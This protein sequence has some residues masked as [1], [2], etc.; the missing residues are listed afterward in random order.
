M[1]E[2]VDVSTVI[3][4]A[5]S[6]LAP[7]L[8]SR[9]HMVENT[10]VHGLSF[11]G[12]PAKLEQLFYNILLNAVQY[13]AD[14]TLIR[15]R[16]NIT[17]DGFVIAIADAGIGIKRDELGKIFERFYRADRSRSR[18]RGGAGLGL[19]IV[20]AI[21]DAHG[22]GITVESTPDAGTEFLLGF[23]ARKNL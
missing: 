15:I 19:A 8:V 14:G 11:Q 13:S 9:Q 4:R 23:P 2:D 3:A 18:A 21:A 5:Q 12:S 6:R 1:Y 10:V 20:K 22:I 17:D 7:L 16:S